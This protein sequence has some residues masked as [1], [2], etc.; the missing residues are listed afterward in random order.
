MEFNTF[1][2]CSSSR[3]IQPS[4]V[5]GTAGQVEYDEESNGKLHH[6]AGC[7]EHRHHWQ[8]IPDALWGTGLNFSS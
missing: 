3:S 4:R 8:S 7:L 5:P 6:G 2:H 1:W